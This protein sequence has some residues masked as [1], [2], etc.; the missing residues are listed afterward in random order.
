MSAG[1]DW[2]EHSTS[3]NDSNN[4]RS[5]EMN[6]A[7]SIEFTLS[8][9]LVYEPGEVFRYSG[10]YVTVIGEI[11]R[12]ATG[13]TSL[14]DFAGKSSLSKL[15]LI[16]AYWYKQMD[17][18]QNAAGGLRL[19]PR[20]MAK[21][22]QIV[23]DKGIWNDQQIIDENWIEESTTKDISTNDNNWGEYG[24]YWWIKFYCVD[25]KKYRAIAARGWG[26]QRIIIIEDLNLVV[27][28]TAENFGRRTYDS[29]I[30]KSFIISAFQ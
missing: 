23:L 8:I 26:G 12:N 17:G 22:G 4:M 9:P 28:I 18:R 24:Y 16:N 14:A 27:V 1:L 29:Q 15:C 13:A 2:D 20:D 11:I 10:G 5:R 30:M 3:Y 21:I 6:S 7:D 25:N 19:R